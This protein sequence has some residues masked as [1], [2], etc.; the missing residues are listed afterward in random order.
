MKN[1]GIEFVGEL[2][3]N[4][5]HSLLALP[6]C[7][8]KTIAEL[9][10]IL[11]ELKLTLGM[12]T[13]DW[14]PGAISSCSASE[15]PE[16]AESTTL[17][18]L[19]EATRYR[20]YLRISE[21][22][23]S[24]RAHN[25]L[26]NAGYK[27]AGDLVPLT[28]ADML[29][30]EGCG[31]R[32]VQEIRMRLIDLGLPVGITISDWSTEAAGSVRKGLEQSGRKEF[33]A[34]RRSAFDLSESLGA[35]NLE[36]ELVGLANA[37]TTPRNSQLVCKL[38]GWT[39]GGRRT[40]ESI[41]EEYGLTRERARQI[42]DRVMRQIRDCLPSTRWVNAALELAQS[43]CPI[44]SHS[45]AVSLK[46]AAVSREDFDPTGLASACDVLGLKFGLVLFRGIGLYD[47]ETAQNAFRDILRSARR[48]TGANGCV[49]FDALYDELALPEERRE[50]YRRVIGE[51]NLVEW[52]DAQHQWL[53][54]RGRARNRLFNLVAKVLSVSPTINLGDLRRAVARSRRLEIAPPAMVI[55]EFV[56]V[57]GI[58]IVT[59][60]VVQATRVFP[61]TI[62][63]GSAEAT[64]IRVI[65]D[66]GPVLDWETL[67]ELCV[68][69]GMNRTTASIYLSVSPIVARLAKGVYALVG[70]PVPP[71]L[72]EEI[73]A[74]IDARRKAAEFGWSERGTLWCAVFI[75]QS[76]LTSGAIGIPSFV[77]GLTS[78]TEWK[79]SIGGKTEN[80]SVK[81]SGNFIWSF[82]RAL[83]KAGGDAG[84][85][86]VLEF[87]LAAHTVDLSVGDEDLIEI[88]ENGL[89]D[90][91][92]NRRVED[93]EIDDDSAASLDA[94]ISL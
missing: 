94:D 82:A 92:R 35:S 52:L 54:F 18:S 66:N 34:V 41:G 65:R 49:N 6:N 3:Q 42:S 26:S 90:S 33:L 74:K 59:N 36:D 45:L 11:S 70:Q 72:V 55:G 67:I 1:A 63:E 12:D 46:D 91:V 50:A 68:E 39:G 87:D 37:V 16:D 27:F 32:S 30:L 57:T 80:S 13:G 10:E 69:A 9:N 4:T 64:M 17:D 8:R 51:A 48:S 53:M 14:A 84:D 38:W 22:G 2:V 89:I 93:A 85:V 76:I 24:E 83:A 56:K 61:G 77:G 88:W 23:L 73:T 21:L 86:C 44:M 60:N 75:S 78:G 81:S 40:L 5:E 43:Q 15:P 71:G 20:L 58:G 19:S 62:E 25:I 47:L 29:R 31:R 7:G 28:N 79:L